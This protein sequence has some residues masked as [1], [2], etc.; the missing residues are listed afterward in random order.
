M[1]KHFIV[2]SFVA[3]VA[4]GIIVQ[5]RYKPVRAE[6]TVCRIGDSATDEVPQGS[7]LATLEDN[8]ETATC[9]VFLAAHELFQEVVPAICVAVLLPPALQSGCC[10]T[11]DDG[12]ESLA[13]HPV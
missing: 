8:H 11:S 4:H 6:D 9:E 7:L 1:A 13:V 2:G 12:R 10:R 3:D 5:D